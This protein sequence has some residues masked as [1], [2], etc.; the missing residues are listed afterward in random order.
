MNKANNNETRQLIQEYVENN[1]LLESIDKNIY[2]YT[3]IKGLY[4]I[5]E[6]KKFYVTDSEYLNDYTEIKYFQTIFETIAES[7]IASNIMVP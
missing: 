3:D 4:G 7:I 6:N 1:G 5:I 2:H